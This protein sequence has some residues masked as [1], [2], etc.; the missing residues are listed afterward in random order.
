MENSTVDIKNDSG[1][2]KFRDINQNFIVD[3][4]NRNLDIVNKEWISNNKNSENSII[5]NLSINKSK[6]LDISKQ[7]LYFKNT[8]FKNEKVY[9]EDIYVPLEI[10][11]DRNI[12]SLKDNKPVVNSLYSVDNDF[13]IEEI[14]KKNNNSIINIIGGA[15]QGKSTVLSKIFI[16]QLKK[17]NLI[18]IFLSFRNIE[19]NIIN[20]IIQIFEDNGIP[21]P[22]GEIVGLLR[23]KRFVLV[24][25]AFDEI[26]DDSLK[27]KIIHEI[28]RMN[29]TYGLSIVCSSR[30]GTKLC[31]QSNVQNYD[32]CDLSLG[33]TDEIIDKTLKIYDYQSEKI[34]NLLNKENGIKSSLKTPLLTV[35]FIKIYPEMEVIPEHARDFYDQIFFLL[36]SGHDKY[37][38]GVEINRNLVTQYSRDDT[39]L[40][41]SLFSFMTFIN[42]QSSFII[43]AANKYLKTG[44]NYFSSKISDKITKIET[45]DFLKDIIDCTSLLVLDGVDKGEDYYTFLHKTIQE[46]HAAIFFR[47][48]IKQ[49]LS[50]DKVDIFIKKFIEDMFLDS[51]KIIEFIKFYSVIDKNYSKRKILYPFLNKYFF[52]ENNSREENIKKCM[53]V[54][55]ENYLKDGSL[56]IHSKLEIIE[57]KTKVIKI[58][59]LDNSNGTIK[60][61]TIFTK[62][63]GTLQLN[64]YSSLRETFISTSYIYGLEEKIKEKFDS[65][66]GI[67]TDFTSTEIFPIKEKDIDRIRRGEIIHREMSITIEDLIRKKEYRS[68]YEHMQKTLKELSEIIF[69][70]FYLALQR[71]IE[72]MEKDITSIDSSIEDLFSI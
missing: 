25:D 71:D 51:S 5:S 61:S 10:Q 43:D 50:E 72:R 36:H 55:F 30:P 41:F 19:T 35:L 57:E 20:K 18:P 11:I 7:N 27:T 45:L 22:N 21:C 56:K 63:E 2:I 47:D 34:V 68:T 16:N 8:F 64:L 26:N 13:L 29:N 52:D 12:R 3:N 14:F 53:E 17:G 1:T 46:Y 44:V 24:I 69:D 37:K 66:I 67:T 59:K 70:D 40:L 15:G 54:L 65:L 39:R 28:N 48:F 23:S 58:S 62:D 38:D 42:N 60:E 31:F 49:E 32:L 4:L 33:K 9:F 6:I